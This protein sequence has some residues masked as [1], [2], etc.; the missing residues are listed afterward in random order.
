RKFDVAG[1]PGNNPKLGV[2]HYFTYSDDVHYTRSKHSLSAGGWI[3]RVQQGQAGVA[4]S[5]AGNVAYASVLTFLQDMPTQAIVTRNAPGLGY[6]SLEAAWYVQ[7][8]IKLLRNL[9]LRLGLRDE[10]TNGWNEALGRC[11]NYFHD[12][13]FVI[14]TNPNIRNCCLQ[15]NQAELRHFS[16]HWFRSEHADPHHPDLE[17]HGGTPARQRPHARGGL[18]GQPVLPHQSDDGCQYRGA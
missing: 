6:R 7:D 9:T 3:Q 5:S 4:L 14:Q 12:A 2:R 11:T 17:L 16:T 10:M 1:A 15:S 13:N 18:C 8:E